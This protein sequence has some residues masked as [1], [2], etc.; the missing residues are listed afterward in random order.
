MKKIAITITLLLSANFIAH[1]EVTGVVRG[2][3]IIIST[4]GF[5][6]TGNGADVSMVGLE[7]LSFSGS[8]IP[9]DPAIADPFAFFLSNTPDSIV[10]ASVPAPAVVADDQIKIGFR[11]DFEIE[12]FNVSYGDADSQRIAV[13][14]MSHPYPEP[15]SGGMAVVAALGLLGIRRRR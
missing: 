10:M 6:V 3:Q 4:N 14:L 8:L 1:A 5:D 7:V 13:H 12:D 2:D 11:G 15:G 9:F